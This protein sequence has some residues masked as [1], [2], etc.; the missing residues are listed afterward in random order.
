MEP[1]AENLAYAK[2]LAAMGRTVKPFFRGA[3]HPNDLQWLL[4]RK[5]CNTQDWATPEL[6]YRASAWGA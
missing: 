1:P 5:L 2:K 3:A 4:H 6:R